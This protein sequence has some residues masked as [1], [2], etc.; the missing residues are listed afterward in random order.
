MNVDK[1]IARIRQFKAEHKLTM[2]AFARMAELHE[3]TL[4]FIDRDDWNP[5]AETLRKLEAA[6]E[7]HSEGKAA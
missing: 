3:N 5:S 2:A 4:R 7:R 6:V 1:A